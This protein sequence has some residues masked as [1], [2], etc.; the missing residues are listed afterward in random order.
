MSL[1]AWPS[2]SSIGHALA[3]HHPA[4][5]R[6]VCAGLQMHLSFQ[7][8]ADTH[9]GA[10]VSPMACHVLSEALQARLRTKNAQHTSGF[11]PTWPPDSWPGA[12]TPNPGWAHSGKPV[13]DFAVSVVSWS[14]RSIR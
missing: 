11:L 1:P 6:Q 10:S 14:S 12:V 3:W 7:E 4:L 2:S 8:K 5:W 9:H 13:G